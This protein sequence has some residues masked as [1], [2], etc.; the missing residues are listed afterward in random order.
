MYL[1][2]VLKTRIQRLEI[3]YLAFI[4]LYNELIHILLRGN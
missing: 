1:C 2:S 3:I 4:I